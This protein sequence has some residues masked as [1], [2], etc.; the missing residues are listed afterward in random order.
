MKCDAGIRGAR[1]MI[2]RV[3]L[4]AAAAALS[5]CK[6]GP[7]Y[8]EP[9]DTSPDAY[10]E[11]EGI[12]RSNAV[13][14]RVWWRTL[15]D[16][17]LDTLVERALRGNLDL[18]EAEARVREARELR[19][20]AAAP[21]LPTVDAK[22][23]YT[24]TEN[25]NNRGGFGGFGNSS[26][27]NSWMLGFDAT[28]ELDFFGRIRR[29][30]E[31]GD[32]TIA[33]R[34]YDTRDVMVTVTSEVAR[35]YV[36]LRTQQRR[37]RITQ[38]NLNTQEQTVEL[39]QAR[40]DAGLTSELD[41]TRARANAETTR[42]QLPALEAQTRRTMHALAVLLG[43]N[44]ETLA[45]EL[46]THKAI[47]YSSDGIP[48]GLP[49]ELL[50]RRPDI[51]VSERELAAQVARIGVATGD[52]YPKIVL[53]G[54]VGWQA[55]K[56]GEIFDASSAENGF[57][58]SVTWRIFDYGRI[59]ANIRAESARAE[60]ALV[61]YERTVI[62]ALQ[63]VED[64]LASYGRERARREILQRAVD[65]GQRAVDI[66]NDLY[67]NGLTDFNAVLDAQRQLF[68][69]Q[70]TLVQSEGLVTTNL[71]AVYKALGGGWD[72]MNV[73]GP[74]DGPVQEP[75]KVA[76]ESGNETLPTKQ[77]RGAPPR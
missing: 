51:R 44:P 24:R 28:W 73:E 38:E 4:V 20:I 71:V 31:S 65:A 17:Q 41:V 74:P 6:V 77:N 25:S 67:R 32:A 56:L 63:E 43:Q 46:E 10:L 40:F 54:N 48:L 69:S 49:S 61:R 37:L 1:A 7:D 15:H 27:F 30:V 53:N 76:D 42:A 14:L 64:A 13:D 59:S 57:G 39:V 75:A 21:L 22:A 45:A 55:E 68:I 18:R 3:G 19:S 33:A 16:E 58:P 62:T 2:L 9:G 12:E 5:G 70:D 52:L 23:G 26:A 60:R 66:S 11:S 50:R 29:D 36:D 35:N 72:L 34:I 47:P 8:K